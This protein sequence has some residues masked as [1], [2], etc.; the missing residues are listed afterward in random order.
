MGRQAVLVAVVVISSMDRQVACLIHMFEELFGQNV[1]FGWDDDVLWRFLITVR[2]NY[3]DV[4]YHNFNHAFKV[5][6]LLIM[7]S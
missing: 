1:V 4:V 5:L 6:G 3:R 2:K 7:V